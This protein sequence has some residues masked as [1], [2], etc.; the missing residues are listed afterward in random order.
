MVE[1]ILPIWKEKGMTSFAC[2]SRIR[3]LLGIKKV[4]HAG[5]LDPE[6]EG[7]LPIAVGAGT[8]VL[9]YMLNADKTYTG[10]ITIG[11][12]TSTEDATG[13]I[14]ERLPVSKDIQEEEIDQVLAEFVGSIEQIPPMFSAVKV[15][16]KKLYEYAFEGIEIERSARKVRIDEL[17]RTSEIIYDEVE[18]TVRFSFEVSCSKGTYIRTLAVD[19]GKKLG[20]PAHMSELTRIRSGNILADQTYTLEEVKA[21]LT[22][23]NLENLLLPIDVGLTQ[24]TKITI[25]DKLWNR[26][27]NGALLDEEDITTEEYPVLFVY[28]QVIVALYDKHPKKTGKL[29]PLKMFKIEM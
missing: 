16:G 25:D 4:G 19:I 20:Y 7:V 18:K 22:N 9:E 13:T 23:D 10:E 1:G 5:T 6:V 8:K 21:A 15:K 3:Y 17:K 29:K 26:V 12:S 14:I 2:V 27:K 28:K 24:F 11:Y